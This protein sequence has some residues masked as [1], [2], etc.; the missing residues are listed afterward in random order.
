MLI[1]YIDL[2]NVLQVEMALG[3]RD[4]HPAFRMEDLVPRDLWQ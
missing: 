1:F 2:F 4:S 3:V